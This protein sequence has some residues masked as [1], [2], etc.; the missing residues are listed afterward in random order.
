MCVALLVGFP[1]KLARQIRAALKDELVYGWEIK[2]FP[3]RNKDK[4]EIDKRDIAGICQK[5]ADFDGAHVI[6]FHQ[7]GDCN[8]IARDIRTFFR[9][10]RGDCKLLWSVA[11]GFEKFREHI[12]NSLTEELE[13]RKHIKPVSKSSPLV[14]P[15]H[16][17]TSLQGFETLWG[18]SEMFN[19]EI[20]YFENLAKRIHQFST[21][22]TKAYKQDNLRFMV[23]R[24]R[25][26][27]KDAGPY[28][29][30]PPF[31]FNWKYSYLLEPGFHFDVEHQ[32][33]KEFELKDAQGTAHRVK[34]GSRV[35]IDPHGY[36][37][38]G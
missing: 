19:R 30:N 31:P 22:H 26:V 9:F 3:G 27:W 1:E 7:I 8:I 34:A 12:Q 23:D 38:H 29:A 4:A 16:V 15:Q 36:R 24:A 18:E 37:S 32:Q 2:F 17:F 5:A 11:E 10:R 25:L 13:W 14:L 33:G 28:H 21:S 20:Q 6:G 35:N